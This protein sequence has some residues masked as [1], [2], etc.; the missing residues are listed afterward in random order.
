MKNPWI[1]A[2][3]NLVPIGLGYFY[4]GRWVRAVLALIVG[5]LLG[6]LSLVILILASQ[7]ACWT[8]ACSG[9]DGGGLAAL[10]TF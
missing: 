7:S 6:W 8:G 2:G 1:A 4:L 3:L 10:A 5:T 9:S